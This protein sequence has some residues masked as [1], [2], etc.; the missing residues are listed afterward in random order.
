[1]LVSTVKHGEDS[2]NQ[3]LTPAGGEK[4][5][6]KPKLTKHQEGHNHP[7]TIDENE[8]EDEEDE[9]EE[10]ELESEEL[11]SEAIESSVDYTPTP[12]VKV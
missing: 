2:N 12:Q 1:M 6:K 7:H 4:S 3:T 9:D 5:E 8:D 11:D 10:D